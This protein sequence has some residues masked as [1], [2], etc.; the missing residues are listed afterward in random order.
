M[1]YQLTYLSG[2]NKGLTVEFS[3]KAV[4]IGRDADNDMVI[5]ESHVSGDHAKLVSRD[6]QVFIE[7][8]GST[9]GTFVN[10]RRITSPVVLNTGDTVQLGTT[11]KVRFT[12]LTEDFGDQTVVGKP[13]D[14]PNYVPAQKSESFQEAPKKKS[15]PKWII[16]AV[17]GVV[18]LCGGVILLGGGGLILFNW[19]SGSDSMTQQT[20]DMSFVETDQVVLLSTQMAMTEAPYATETAQAAQAMSPL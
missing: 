19:F 9:N 18:I 7:D 20:T 17:I 14:L 2:T 15:F 4:F 16:F 5:D 8:L 1:Q 11:V 10:G 12:A 6:E 13:E 3:Q